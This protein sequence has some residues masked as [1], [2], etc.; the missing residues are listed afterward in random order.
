[1]TCGGRGIRAGS[2]RFFATVAGGALL[3]ALWTG[4][5]P[6]L[7]HR[8]FTAHMVL[9]MGVVAV[10][11]P[12]FVLGLAGGTLDP[13][14]RW[15]ALFAP[16]P[17]AV[18]E[19]LIV[20]GWHAPAM[21]ESARLDSGL[22]VVEQTS[23]L[24]A[25]LLVWFSALGGDARRAAERSG[26]GALGLLLTSM[27]MT[28]LGALLALSSRPLYERPGPGLP[29]LTPLEDQHVGGAVMLGVGGAA[30]LAGGVYLV[31]RLLRLGVA[32]TGDVAEGR[33]T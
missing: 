32:D 9:H 1:V 21:H 18:V 33:P 19:L 5:L 14:R 17:A 4:P 28:L 25:G 10:A 24:L 15:P 7:A 23:F 20:W 27:H 22:F 11:A 31:A 13:A 2:G 16:V 3:L 8:A 12:L 26:A 6:A 30:Y 29:G